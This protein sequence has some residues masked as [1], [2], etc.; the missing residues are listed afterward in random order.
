MSALTRTSWLARRRGL[1]AALAAAI[2][3]LTLGSCGAA[4]SSGTMQASATFSDVGDLPNG[5]SVE[6]VGVII[7]HVTAITLDH[8]RAR[9]TLRFARSAHVP[10]AVRAE[11]RQASLLGPKVINL[12]PTSDAPNQPLL[13]DKAVITDAQVVP[14]LQDL[15]KAGTDVIGALSGSELA[16]VVAEGAKGFGGK[17]PELHQTLDDLNTVMA[18]F[19]S[20]TA[21]ITKLLGDLDQLSASLAPNAGA[22]A[23]A[24]SN[25]AAT[26]AVLDQEKQKLTDLIGSLNQVSAQGADLLAQHLPQIE[27]QLTA[28]KS[29]TQAV[30]NQQAA[31]GGV[32]TYL[33]GHNAATSLGTVND[34]IQVLNDFVICG[35]PGGGE[36]PTSPLNACSYVPSPAGHP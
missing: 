22:N 7:G 33:K 29:V 24:L 1:A 18:G 8:N 13:A 23:Q 3:L 20:H 31:F 36:D 21:T 25:L 14:T 17:G 16:T 6:M 32:L 15:V 5:G 30:A 35:V 11:V 4:G 34:F 28:L 27:N 19:A 12:V 2:T 9:L 10:A 26:V